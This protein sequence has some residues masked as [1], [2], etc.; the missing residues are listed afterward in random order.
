MAGEIYYKGFHTPENLARIDR[1]RDIARELELSVSGLALAWLR[2]HERTTA[3]IVAPR[4]KSQW[5]A[6]VEA[7]RVR[8][9]PDTFG[10]ISEIFD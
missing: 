3:P 10:R 7:D 6:V 9:E 1:L 4:M 2:D 5:D 8:L